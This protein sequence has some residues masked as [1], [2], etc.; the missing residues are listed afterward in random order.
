MMQ[1]RGKAAMHAGYWAGGVSWLPCSA[2]RGPE[3]GRESMSMSAPVHAPTAV[4]VAY[5]QATPGVA[6]PARTRISG[7]ASATA[8]QG[9]RNELALAS[10]RL[11]SLPLYCSP[12]SPLECFMK[13][14]M[15]ADGLCDQIQMRGCSGCSDYCHRCPERNAPS[16]S[17]R[18]APRHARALWRNYRQVTH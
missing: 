10:P 16:W 4:R 5:L 17:R 14:A 13:S 6:H 8:D 3:P 1:W 11:A 15:I 2:S 7:N 9:V 18:A 12:D